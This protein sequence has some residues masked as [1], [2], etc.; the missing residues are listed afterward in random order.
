MQR[1]LH[2]HHR[3]EAGEGKNTTHSQKKLGVDAL[4]KVAQRFDIPV[5]KKDAEELNFYKPAEDSEELTYLRERR[6]ALGGFLPTRSF[7]LE[8]FN[9]P[10]LNTF[11]PLLKSTEEKEMSSTMAFVRL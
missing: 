5:T 1:C 2:F 11:E 7:E 6:E 9:I 10:Q 4:V 3:G 8:S